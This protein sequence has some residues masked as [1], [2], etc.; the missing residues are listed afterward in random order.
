LTKKIHIP[1]GQPCTSCTAATLKAY[2]LALPPKRCASNPPV[3][4]MFKPAVRVH[5]FSAVWT[6]N[7]AGGIHLPVVRFLRTPSRPAPRFRCILH[8]CHTQGLRLSITPE[9]LCFESPA[10]RMF[11]PIVRVH[12]LSAVYAVDGA[13]GIRLPV[14][15][16]LRTPSRPAPRFRCVLHR[17]LTQGLRLGIIPEALCFESPGLPDV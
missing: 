13:G 14:V 11:K 3:Y 12:T 17:Y 6:T 9:A 16:F 2:A 4:R 15:R 8:R 1:P 10:Y 7:G 5:T